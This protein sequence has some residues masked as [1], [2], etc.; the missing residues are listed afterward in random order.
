MN[1]IKLCLLTAT[2]FFAIACEKEEIPSSDQGQVTESRL[3]SYQS[4][5]NNG[6]FWSLWKSDGSTGTCNYQNGAGGNYSVSWSNFTGNF[7]CGKGYSTGSPNYRIGYNLGA[8]TNTGGGTFGWYGWTRNPYYEYYVN[9]TWGASSPHT[10]TYLGTLQSD[11][12]GYNVYTRWVSGTNIDGGSGFRQIYSSRNWKI[13]TGKNYVITFANHYN[14]WKS[15][16]YTLGQMNIPA[17]MVTESWGTNVSGYA[18]CTIWA[19]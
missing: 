19:N 3:K 2:L 10:G 14:K 6:F 4:G 17:I 8:Y 18:N 16:G 11:G 12:G 9:E 15:L 13:Q 5:T 1:S 7:T